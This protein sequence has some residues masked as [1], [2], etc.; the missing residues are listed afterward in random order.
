MVVRNVQ[1]DDVNLIMIHFHMGA[2]GSI[3]VKALHYKSDGPGIDS[4]GVTGDFFRGSPR[5][6]HVD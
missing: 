6:N 4:G 1:N 2:W 5:Q 3:V